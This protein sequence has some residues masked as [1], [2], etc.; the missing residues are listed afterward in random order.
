[1]EEEGD[2]D[3][4]ILIDSDSNDEPNAFFG[5]PSPYHRRQHHQFYDDEAVEGE[6]ES[7]STESDN[8]FGLEEEEEEEVNDLNGTIHIHRSGGLSLN[9]LRN[10]PTSIPTPFQRTS[11]SESTFFSALTCI[12]FKESCAICM[13]SFG[14]AKIM[15][16]P[17]FHI[18]HYNCVKTWFEKSHICPECRADA[19]C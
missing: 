15:T 12:T 2:D 5:T 13:E 14:T 19:R 10:L 4:Q 7:P 18:F 16:L 17:C 6:P 9:Q 11:G 3:E 8:T 1:M